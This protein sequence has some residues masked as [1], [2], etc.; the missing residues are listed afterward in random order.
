MLIYKVINKINGKIY[1]GQTAGNFERRKILHLSR[2]RGVSNLPFYNAIRK[3]GPEDFVWEILEECRT[4]EELNEREEYWI[5]EL[6]TIAPNGYNL[7]Y[8][9]KNSLYSEESRERMSEAK[10]GKKRK[11]FSE[12]HRKNMSEAKQGENHPMYGKSPSEEA[13]KNM[14]IASK[15]K[16]KSKKHCENISKSKKGENHPRAKLTNE[17]VLDIRR[18]GE[19]KIDQY[20]IAKMKN[21]S[22]SVVNLIINYKIWKHI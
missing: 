1:V 7:K 2:A 12:E 17:D 9:G 15:G 16:P 22:Q 10:K 5:K 14:S 18:M 4:I 11:P 20:E 6:N 21:I 19:E 8:G 13:R 3:Y